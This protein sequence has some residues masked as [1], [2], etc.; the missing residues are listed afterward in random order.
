MFMHGLQTSL[1]IHTYL[2]LFSLIF[3]F[4]KGNTS[5]VIHVLSNLFNRSDFSNRFYSVVNQSN[6][7]L[8]KLT[9]YK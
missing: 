1:L 9:M 4:F 8:Y 7:P 2:N 3:F 5:N 6:I